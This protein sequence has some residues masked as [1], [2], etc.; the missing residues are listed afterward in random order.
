MKQIIDVSKAEEL[1]EAYHTSYGDIFNSFYAAFPNFL[2]TTVIF[3]LTAYQT[4]NTLVKVP[5]IIVLSI[6]TLTTFVFLVFFQ[7]YYYNLLTQMISYGSEVVKLSEQI[8][9][10]EEQQNKQSRYSEVENTD[11][12]KVFT[13]NTLNITTLY[14][15][16]LAITWLFYTII[17]FTL[18]NKVEYTIGFSCLLFLT[19][20]LNFTAHTINIIRNYIEYYI[21]KIV[22]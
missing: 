22:V 10:F 8:R 4:L 5:N 12:A 2:L 3:F 16:F 21:K 15:L 7:A 11:L 19:I 9:T 6:L 17:V 18:S 20:I 14:Y 1:K 13:R